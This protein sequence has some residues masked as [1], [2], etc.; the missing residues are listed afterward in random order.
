MEITAAAKA[1]QAHDFVT[2]LSEGYDPH[3]EARG[4]NL[5][6]GQKQRVAIARAL[7]TQ[8]RIL[9]LDDSTSAVDVETE[10]EIQEAL[11]DLMAG[12][13]SFVV[14][15]RISTVLKA[16]KIIVIDKGEIVAEGTHAE[17][18]TT[19]PIYQEIYDSQL[20]DG[21]DIKNKM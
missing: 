14:A 3:V 6:G 11:D 9:I 13:T 20:G 16:D 17:L 7:L 15:Q 10:I 2:G 21:F 19:S 18:I 8:P 4:V 1:A 12:R 5:S